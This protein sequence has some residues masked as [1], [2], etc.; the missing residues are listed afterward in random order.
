MADDTTTTSETK[1]D[2]PFKKPV[3]I[4]RIGKL[5]KK[6]KSETVNTYEENPPVNAKESKETLAPESSSKS[7]VST[8]DSSKE[9]SCPVAY[10]E[11]QWSGMCPDGKNPNESR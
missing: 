10:K 6:A 1:K 3:L 2:E 11:P 4:G 7:I 5:P 9:L 8:Q